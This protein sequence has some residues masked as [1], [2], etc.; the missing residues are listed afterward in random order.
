[1]RRE[2]GRKNR[3][4]RRGPYRSS[5]R[6]AGSY[7]DEFEEGGAYDDYDDYD[8]DG[9]DDYDDYSEPGGDLDEEPFD[10]RSRHGRG[11]DERDEYDEYDEV[12]S[13]ARFDEFDDDEPDEEFAPPPRR[14]RRRAGATERPVRETRRRAGRDRDPR[15][16][17]QRRAKPSRRKAGRARPGA[18]DGARE[19]ERYDEVPVAPPRRRRRRSRRKRASLMDFCTPVFACVSM[20]PREPGAVQPGYQEFRDQVTT[21]LRRLE[22]EA[23]NHGIDLE[24]AREAKYALALLVDDQVAESEWIGKGQWEPLNED[25]EGGVNFFRKLEQFGRK[26]K[27]AKAVYLV[28][29][30]FGYRGQYAELDPTEQAAKVDAIRKNLIDDLHPRPLLKAPEL[31]PEAYQ[32]PIPVEQ[33]VPPPPR[34]WL[35]ASAGAVILALL[36]FLLLFWGAG[37]LPGGAEQA[38]TAAL[39]RSGVA[40]EQHASTGAGGGAVEPQGGER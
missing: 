10:D 21:A 11:F 24:D 1:M 7:E 23:P 37:R 35:A 30:A 32:E 13:P 39:E 5:G 15:E 17:R 33:E 14:R 31:F 36:V 9:Y 25:P 3:R 34:W 40:V 12:G 20:L 4:G 16:S 22:T 27:A 38:V 18:Y 28:C 8:D 6:D 2:D 19:R 29:L 26:R